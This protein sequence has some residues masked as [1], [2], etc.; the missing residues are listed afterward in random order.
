MFQQ[1]HFI[2]YFN[3]SL[4]FFHEALHQLVIIFDVKIA[5]SS[6]L[7]KPEGSL[8]VL[9]STASTYLHTNSSN[10]EVEEIMVKKYYT[11]NFSKQHITRNKTSN[12]FIKNTYT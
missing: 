10:I 6:N 2:L 9:H 3:I 4:S 8:A 5:P 12:S 1:I 7:F 11:I